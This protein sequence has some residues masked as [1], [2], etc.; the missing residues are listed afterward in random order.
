MRIARFRVVTLTSMIILASVTNLGIALLTGSYTI[1]SSGT[2]SYLQ[3]RPLHTEGRHIKDDLGNNVALRGA[4]KA[5]PGFA[6]SC[7]GIYAAEGEHYY[8]DPAQT[9]W[10]E[11][12]VRDV[13]GSMKDWGFNSFAEFIWCDWWIYNSQTL[14]GYRRDEVQTDTA[15]RDALKSL[16]TLANEEGLYVQLRP[17]GVE[18]GWAGVGEG[19]VEFPFPDGSPYSHDGHIFP[20]AQSFANFWYDVAYE[21]AGY[22][23]VIFNLYDE[24]VTDPIT[25]WFDAA[26]LCIQKIRQAEL[27]AGG[28]THIIMV[29]WAYCADCQWIAQWINEGRPTE[30]IVFSNHVYR[31]HGTFEDNPN[32]PTDINYIRTQLADA[33][34]L[35]YKYIQDTYNI[36]VMVTAI[37]AAY[38]A[39]NDGEYTCFANCL[40]V[41]NEWEMGYWA[42]HWYPDDPL[43]SINTLSATSRGPSY[44]NRV[45]QALIDA[46]VAGTT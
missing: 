46:I 42:Y 12:A 1:H 32:S 35:A 34:K 16:L 43:W 24:P 6:D 28:Y 23:N 26:Q 39:T 5:E 20:D 3:T 40:S 21:L 19:R 22:P 41:F 9:Q 7:V 30:N 15:Y 11:D 44:A 27:D 33:D 31:Y 45:G 10:R 37:G 4:W 14:L 13:L 36:P 25:R 29:H 17:Y 38:G 18:A 2:L 8:S